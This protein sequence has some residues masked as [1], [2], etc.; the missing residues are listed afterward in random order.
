MTLDPGSDMDDGSGDV[1]RDA[2]GDPV[3]DGRE[4]AASAR[5]VAEPLTARGRRTRSALLLAARQVFER[6][7]Y[8]DSRVTD[9]AEAAG[10]GH[11]TFYTYFSSKDDVLRALIDDL[12]AELRPRPVGRAGVVSPYDTIERANRSYVVAFRDHAALMV[13]WFQVAGRDAA[14]GA[15]LDAEREAYAARAERSIRR[16]QERGLADAG[17]DPYYTAR[18]LCGMVVEMCAQWF[19][20]GLPFELEPTVRTL[21]EVWAKAIGLA[22]DDHDGGA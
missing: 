2:P 10:T 5:P 12:L 6:D 7:G 19:R 14:L 4:V 1:A 3:R 20:T 9:I 13:L 8:E 22:R 11:G 15:L 16:L 18:A 21:T 17:L